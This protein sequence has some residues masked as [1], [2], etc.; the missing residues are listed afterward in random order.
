MASPFARPPPPY[1]PEHPHVILD[2]EKLPS[3][4]ADLP[5]Q[6]P[7]DSPK[8]RGLRGKDGDIFH[9]AP[10]AALT[11]LARYTELLV[12]M[13]GDVPPN[14]PPSDPT[15]PA[16]SCQDRRHSGGG[17]YF[18]SSA[19]SVVD[20]IRIKSPI[21]TPESEGDDVFRQGKSI[22]HYGSVDDTT[23]YGMIAR[24]FWCKTA[25]EIPIEEY[26]FRYVSP[27][28]I[29]SLCVLAHA[30]PNTA[31]PPG[32]RFS[33]SGGFRNSCFLLLSPMYIV[34]SRYPAAHTLWQDGV[35]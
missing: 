22:I 28:L 7:S 23:H 18:A 11:L 26:L 30:I 25:P 29:P 14:P 9:L 16:N 33:R 12:R 15:T 24:K 8:P 13:T 5:P 2:H 21:S 32:P 20:G 27:H 1:S 35:P 6:L 19:S 3:V 4:M 17:Y 34:F 10:S 31:Q